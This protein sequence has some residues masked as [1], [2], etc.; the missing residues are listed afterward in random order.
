MMTAYLGVHPPFFYI[1][2]SED[3]NVTR[4]WAILGWERS[5]AG[6]LNDDGDKYI[7]MNDL[8]ASLL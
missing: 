8:R 6:A 7:V 1:G 5:P 4:M 3:S 2:G